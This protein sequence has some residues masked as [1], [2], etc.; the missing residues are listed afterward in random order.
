VDGHRTNWDRGILNHVEF[1]APDAEVHR[2]VAHWVNLPNILSPGRIAT[3][4]AIWCG[5]W[6]VE[7]D[8]WRI[9]IDRRH[10]LDEVMASAAARPSYVLTHVMELRR[11]DGEAFSVETA[12][13]L[14]DGLRVC[15]SFAFGRWIAPILPVG[16]NNREEVV[17]EEWTTPI[18]DRAVTVGFGRLHRTHTDDLTRLLSCACPDSLHRER[19]ISCV[20]R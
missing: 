9:M 4:K 12:K 18:C 6:R 17:W 8:G 20:T 19:R 2:V 1:A 10:D 14:L 5:R 16:Y 13:G 11:T 7:G 3:E 15:M